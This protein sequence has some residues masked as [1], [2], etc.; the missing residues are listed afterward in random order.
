MCSGN[1]W[2]RVRLSVGP[3]ESCAGQGGTKTVLSKY[4]GFVRH[5]NSTTAPYVSIDGYP[6]AEQY[7]CMLYLL[8]L[9]FLDG[10][11]FLPLLMICVG[12]VEL[13]KTKCGY[14]HTHTHTLRSVKIFHASL[15]PRK[16]R[17]FE[18]FSSGF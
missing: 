6:I 8:A 5:F 12:L 4:F 9:S 16:I 3:C 17:L 2:S 7:V 1:V 11:L 10:C 15:V 13:Q 18:V 14:T